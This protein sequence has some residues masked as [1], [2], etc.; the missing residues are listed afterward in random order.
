MPSTSSALIVYVWQ[1]DG[2]GCRRAWGYAGVTI[3]RGSMPK[4]TASLNRPATPHWAKDGR[5][6]A[7]ESTI[8][9]REELR[10]KK[11]SIACGPCYILVSQLRLAHTVPSLLVPG[12]EHLYSRF[13]EI[14][15]FQYVT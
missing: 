10:G 15:I 4:K 5:P 11:V 14:D 8:C 6:R 1:P 9:S 3:R 13:F 7:D 12:T 2:A